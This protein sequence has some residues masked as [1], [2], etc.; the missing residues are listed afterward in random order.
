M[1]F[2]KLKAERLKLKA[3]A[4]PYY[5]IAYMMITHMIDDEIYLNLQ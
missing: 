3:I 2:Q 5:M 1:P 4:N